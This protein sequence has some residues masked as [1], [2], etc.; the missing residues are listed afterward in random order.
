[1][2]MRK[3]W[4]KLF[5]LAACL[6][7]YKQGNAQVCTGSFGDPVINQDF[8]SGASLIGPQ[9][10]SGITTMNYTSD[11]CPGDTY[12]TIA[13]S[14]IGAANCHS[15]V[16]HEVPTDHT[17]NPNGYMMIV[18]ASYDPGIFFTQKAPA[19]C[20]N[21][22]YRF[23][24]YILNL[25]MLSASSPD[26]HQPDITFSIETT[27]G[28][29]LAFRK[30]GPIAPTNDVNWNFYSIN[31]KTPANVTDVIVKMTN[32]APG[33]NGND[34]VLDDITFR[35]CGPNIQTGFSSADGKTTQD[36]CL[37][38][39]QIVTLK[40]KADGDPIYQW[41]Y[42]NTGDNNWAD[43]PDANTDTYF[44]PASNSVAGTYLYR[45]G[46][47]ANGGDINSLSCRTYWAPLAVVV[48]ALPVASITPLGPL[49]EGTPL[50]LTA[51][52]GDAYLWSG[53]N[54]TSASENPLVI[55]NATLADAG[56]YTV[57][58]YRIT[59]NSQ[60]SCAGTPANIQV[61]ITP[62]PVIKVDDIAPICAGETAQLN[63][64]GGLYYKWTPSTG[65]DHDDIPNPKANPLVTTTYNLT[66]SNNACSDNT[67]SVTVAVMQLPTA[68]AG[69][70]KKI[71]EGQSVK[72]N[73]TVTGDNIASISWSP[74]TALNDPTSAT[75]IANPTDDITYTMTVTS[76]NCGSFTSLPIFIKVYKKIII[77]NTFSPNNDGINDLW[78]IEALFTYPESS[79]VVFNRY[80]K[81]VFKSTGYSKAWDGK[82][83]G[84]PL[85]EG[86]YYYIIDLKNNT[87][88]LTGW[89]VIVK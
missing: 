65:L 3:Y 19:L 26:V 57:T 80:G 13:H 40:A 47:V 37:N 67:K 72:L 2:L 86:T 62:K 42:Y 55:N 46:A 76:Q 81:E 88:K 50:I 29:T 16:W 38:D 75:P 12:Y 64:S 51:S 24:A 31:F 25:I 63:A 43:I 34:L 45:V 84:S 70:D 10:A 61:T 9:L 7:C 89:V 60:L 8:G 48:N 35:A 11:N 33:G 5:L 18:N 23:S 79:T 1:L 69:S 53:P 41:Q 4:L 78:N 22:T 66:A 15:G 30:T 20:P 17:G 6:C 36:V 59:P 74:T 39:S 73:G 71:F 85:P 44:R 28:D 68:D 52:G 58:P 32:N 77:P 49:C 56:K 27:A 21:T 82:Y 14:L 54:I 87:P 83:N